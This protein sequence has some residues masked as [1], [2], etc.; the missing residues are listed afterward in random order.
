[1]KKLLSEV[2]RILQLHR[3]LNEG[4]KCQDEDMMEEEDHEE[5]DEDDEGGPSDHDEDNEEVDEAQVRPKSFDRGQDPLKSGRIGHRRVTRGSGTSNISYDGEGNDK[6]SVHGQRKYNGDFKNLPKK[7]GEGGGSRASKAERQ[8]KAKVAKGRDPNM[9]KIVSRDKDKTER[10]RARRDS[11]P[12]F[13]GIARDKMTRKS[14]LETKGKLKG[15]NYS[16]T[17]KLPE[18]NSKPITTTSPATGK[19]LAWDK[20]KKQWNDVK[21]AIAPSTSYGFTKNG[22]LQY[23]G[24]KAKTMQLMKS[25]RKADPKASFQLVYGQNLPKPGMPYPASGMKKEGMVSKKP[26]STKI[27][28]NTVWQQNKKMGIGRVGRKKFGE[29][30]V[31]EKHQQAVAK[32]TLKMNDTFVNIMGGPNKDQAKKILKKQQKKK[33]SR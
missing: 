16:L 5:P 3:F 10:N 26:T 30:G 1:M 6:V 19:P 33:P 17:R 31:P 13:G 14:D 12:T 11:S 18:A 15:K 2:E 7:I 25:E 29:N 27:K 20:K 23:K 28:D 4:K 22:K 21:E 9:P 32:R 8:Q 24:S